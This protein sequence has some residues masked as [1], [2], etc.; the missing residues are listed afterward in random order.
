M[1]R[2]APED[3]VEPVTHA[4]RTQVTYSIR[5]DVSA[6]D[7][8]IHIDMKSA[9]TAETVATC[10][11]KLRGRLERRNARADGRSSSMSRR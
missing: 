5:I 3:S 9:L 11:R 8:G 10:V 4:P 1:R 7:A 6:P 2:I